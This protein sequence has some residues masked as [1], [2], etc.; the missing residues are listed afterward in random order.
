[1]A[2]WNEAHQLRELSV[3]LPGLLLLLLLFLLLRLVLA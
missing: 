2:A 1:M 3:T